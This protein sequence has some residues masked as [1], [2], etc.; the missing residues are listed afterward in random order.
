MRSSH[1]L[2]I[3]TTGAL[4][5]A[6]S[7]PGSGAPAPAAG[8]AVL[9]L[10][11][12]RPGLEPAGGGR[13][14][15]PRI[16][17]FGNASRPGRPMLPVKVLMVA[18]PE[19]S[20]PELRILSAPSEPLGA[21]DIAP[22]PRVR[23]P[24]RL[25]RPRGVGGKSRGR[26]PD[27]QD[28][29]EDFT[30]DEGVY[31]RDEEIPAQAV[32]LGNTGYLRE[33]RYVE[34]LFS[35]VLYNP[36]RRHARFVREAQV[37]V[38]FN[39]PARS[40]T[41]DSGPF[42]PDSLFEATYQ[43][44][45]ANYEQGK[46]FRVRPGVVQA[47]AP[48]PAGA[49][50]AASASTIDAVVAAAA[51]TGVPRYKIAVSRPGIYRLDYSFLMTNAPD[52][53]TV[54]PGTLMLSAE[55]VEVPISIRDASGAS[56]ELD[57]QFGPGD[58]LE[59][60]GQPKRETPTI[61]NYHFGGSFPDIF[62]ANDFTDVQIYWLAPADP[63]GSHLRVPAVSGAPVFPAFP[64]A[65]H[66]EDQAVWDENNIYL[67]L[68]DN[69]PFFSIP[70]LLAGSTQAT[71]DVSIPL[72][73]LAAVAATASVTL[74]LRGGSDLA[75][76]NPDHRTR[77]WVN[78]D[79]GGGDEVTWDGEMI[80]SATFNEAQALLANP[81]VV[82]FSAPGLAGVS[83]DKQYLDSVTIRYQRTFA[84]SG[85]ALLFSYPNQDARFQ[86]S[87]F[88]GPAATIYEVSRTL[89]GSLEADPIRITGAAAG[90]APTTT[91]TFDVPLD[92][93]ASAPTTRWFI[94]AGPSGARLPDGITRAADPVLADPAN[95]ADIIVIGARGT[96][97]PAAGGALDNLLAYRSSSQGLTS[98]IVY[99]DQIYDEFAHGL[100]DVNGIR[101]FL[102]Y[103]FDNW[104]GPAGTAR[105]PAF[106]LLVGDAT[107]DYKNTIGDPGWVDQVP[108][109]MMFQ[110]SSILG[111]YS[112]DNW[113]ASF[114]G[115]D[116]I[117]D[118]YLGRISTRTPLASA[119]VFDK[120]RRYE[121]SPPPGPWKG[122]AILMAGDGK[123]QNPAEANDFESV[124]NTLAAA[125]FSSAP[126][127]TASPLLYF[128]QAPWNSTDAAGYRSA[129]INE[130][131]SGAAVW[132]YVGHGSFETWGATTFFTSEDAAS[133]TNAGP[134][135]FMLNINCLA[136]GFHYMNTIGSLGEEVTNNPDGGAI[137]TL[138][139]SGLT[140]SSIGN[141]VTDNLFGS[142]FGINRDRLLSRAATR[143]RA[144][145]WSEARIVDLQSYTFLGDP[146]TRIA[147]PAPTPPTDLVAV[148]GNGQVALSWTASPEPV[149]GY[150][151]YRATTAAGPYAPITCGPVSSTSCVDAT[152]INAT[153]YY[154]YAVA[155]DAEGFWGPASN[156][157][158]D[159]DAGPSCVLSRPINP[160]PPSVPS[161]LSARDAG[162][163]GTLSVSW[164]AGT[165]R[166]LKWYNLYYSQ[167]SG[168][169]GSKVSVGPGSTS[170]LLTGLEDGIRYYVAIS[171]TNTS[172][173][174]SG[175]SAEVSEV[176]HL[177][178]GIAPPRAIMD[179]RVTRSGSD[180]ILTWSE[181]TVDI[182]GHPTTVVRYNIYQGTTANFP[183]NASHLI[184]TNVGGSNTSF[185]HVGA[186]T[187][188]GQLYYL[189]TAIDS[190]GFASG[191]GR[192][193]P[194]G[195]GNLM[196]TLVSASPTV[197]RLTW[198][199]VMTDLQGYGTIIDHY[200][201]HRTPTPVGR[202]S[203]TAST[204][205]LDN[206]PGPSV[207]LDLTGLSGPSYLSVLAVDNRGNLSPF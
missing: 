203:L 15:V 9:H 119:A 196:L 194:N 136:G 186:V 11:A 56:G 144:A 79:T 22:A 198:S 27:S 32:Q 152:V 178:Q 19:G 164:Q 189:V 71:R 44:S 94:V 97:D 173:N 65:A 153:N 95:A 182:Y 162:I 131:Q 157:N 24:E 107:P 66:F 100:R 206:L 121:Q 52:L 108:T 26:G 37:E 17:G 28:Y 190:N 179:L 176:P 55:G 41:F 197:V 124:Q 29:E 34:V 4:C 118:V 146:A 171:A 87:G 53:L 70:S 140:L 64:I 126:Y 112:S 143:L 58:F 74:R 155:V 145:L 193:L 18:I 120:I 133:L 63:A 135:P 148:S 54:D 36:A 77:V 168:L 116:Q 161:A 110:H 84:A 67:P 48:A 75:A 92:S 45:L 83:L 187:G 205:F 177:V 201:V 204:I 16:P 57:H 154:Y 72:P 39:L 6:F 89:N 199:A 150:R 38:L 2:R 132:S 59:F 61:P 149:A 156:D 174:E 180:L 76:Y 114:R 50:A 117:P 42:E 12:A 102:G 167:Q 207:D 30:A 125:Y 99:V 86:V 35:P 10:T 175:L 188:P 46:L 184:G 3:L 137:A 195:I 158:T 200:Q 13:R 106:V 7:A 104:K 123:P 60:Y 113:L 134:L 127:T 5:A 40:G 98:K 181:P 78:N 191:A 43:D 165:E 183:P 111:Y 185:T 109:P 103:A 69:D 91:F 130:L 129:L 62:Q 163:G 96:L 82:H 202:G 85:D 160:G 90:G 169:Y 151:L 142:L 51:T 47:A 25:E 128:A 101:A 21:L 139:P 138:A 49:V 8:S 93:S 105:P 172:G 141:D 122:R 1:V 80:L 33:Q 73:G 170:T 81:T 14:V 147:T 166:D 159:C 68:D 31:G 192:E 115:T 88:S 23:V 20:V